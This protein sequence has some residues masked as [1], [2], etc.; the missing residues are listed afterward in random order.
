M[1]FRQFLRQYPAIEFME[2]LERRN[3][4]TQE[5]IWLGHDPLDWDNGLLRWNSPAA[6]LRPI[7]KISRSVEG[8]LP[9]PG[10]HGRLN[11]GRLPTAT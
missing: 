9:V 8:S 2:R 11:L 1:D 7:R 4:S 3:S 6:G 10:F 5:R